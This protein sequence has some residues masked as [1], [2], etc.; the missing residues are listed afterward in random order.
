MLNNDVLRSLRYM[1]D[2]SD[3][4]M[5]EIV[6]LGGK[7]VSEEEITAV[8]KKDDEPGYQDCTDDLLAHALDGLVYFKRGKD[9]S[10]P[11]PA[12]ELPVTNNQVLKKLRVA[13]ELKEEDIHAIMRSVDFE[14]SKPEMSALFRKAGTSNYRACGDQFLRN[15]LKGL[16]QRLRD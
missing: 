7:T 14:V 11:A 8:L 1:L 10:R 6:E 9:E 5:V 2:V 15:F 4:K 3:A 12:L 13:F 16:T